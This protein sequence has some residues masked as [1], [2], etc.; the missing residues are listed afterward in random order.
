MTLGEQLLPFAPW[1]FLSGIPTWVVAAAPVLTAVLTWHVSVLKHKSDKRQADREF[2]LK[3]QTQ[4]REWEDKEKDRQNAERS[5][6]HSEN[7][8]QTEAWTKRFTSLMDGYDARVDDLMSEVVQLRQKVE[9]LSRIID[10]QRNACT[11]CP[12]LAQFLTDHPTTPSLLS[13]PDAPG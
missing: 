6:M 5:N 1:A 9:Q 8:A 2:Q 12:K 10:W 7:A 11:G 3:Y 13:A 4:K